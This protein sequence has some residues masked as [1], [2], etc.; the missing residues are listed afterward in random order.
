MT[1]HVQKVTMCLIE[2]L[3]VLSC[4]CFPFTSLLCHVNGTC[5]EFWPSSLLFTVLREGKP[6]CYW[7]SFFFSFPPSSPGSPSLSGTGTVTVLVND[8]NDNVPIFTSS[9][10]HTTIMEDAP[11]GS[12]VLLVNSS[13]ADVGVNGVIRYL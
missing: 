8:V 11:T 2:I 1:S 13:D 5:N 6:N 7:H 4:Y 3:T 12:D 9:T 10:F